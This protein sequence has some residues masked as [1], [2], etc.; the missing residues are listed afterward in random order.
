MR[1]SVNDSVG[2]GLLLKEKAI[3][4]GGTMLPEV[5]REM[6]RTCPSVVIGDPIFT[7]VSGVSSG[8]LVKFHMSHIPLIVLITIILHFTSYNK[9]LL[10]NL[11]VC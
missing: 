2:G 1:N 4:L 9:I 5:L 6:K 11:Q 10:P 7:R 8:I 3:L